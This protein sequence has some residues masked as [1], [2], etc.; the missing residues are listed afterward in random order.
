MGIARSAARSIAAPWVFQILS[1]SLLSIVAFG[2]LIVL[3]W[4]H[5]TAMMEQ[6]HVHRHFHFGTS[7]ARRHLAG[8]AGLEWAHSGAPPFETLVLYTFSKTDPGRNSSLLNH[9]FASIHFMMTCDYKQHCFAPT[10]VL[11]APQLM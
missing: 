11:V 8:L 3:P 7:P 4:S 1:L 10:K 6:E 9:T 5:R 2:L